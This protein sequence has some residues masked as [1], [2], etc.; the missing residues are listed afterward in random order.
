M[1]DEVTV[2][3][4]KVPAAP[5]LSKKAW[6]P[7]WENLNELTWVESFA[8]TSHGVSFGVR[9]S[10]P[11]LI[12]LLKERLPVGA[13]L[14]STKTVDRYF[15][16]ILGGR[17]EGSRIRA[18]HM[19]YLDHTM[20]GRSHRQEEVLDGFESWVR[21]SLG[22]LAPRRVFVH[23]GAVGWKGRA[24]VM[25]GRTFTGKS[26]LV[27][28]LIKRG[29]TYY[30][31]EFAPIDKDG[32]L[33][34]FHKPLSLRDP[35]TGHQSSI[36]VRELGGE[37]GNEPLPIGLIVSSPYQQGARW[38]PKTLSPGSALLEMLSNAVAAQYAPDR[39]MSTLERVVLSTCAIQSR[40]GDAA[41]AADR[42]IEWAELEFT[43]QVQHLLRCCG[44][45]KT[46]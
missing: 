11:A 45:G 3:E 25:P 14:S 37:L 44:D 22:Q 33:H 18:F 32:L 20:F 12:S 9:V 28:E 8:F 46:L 30:S 42:I 29:A 23:A 2:L 31:D 26:T 6:T 5:A 15:S 13:K 1:S 7:C 34:P 36:D 10:D 27:A 40:R 17:K 16:V 35:A 41:R 38:Q 43:R 21:L 19:L 24:I 4:R 39:V